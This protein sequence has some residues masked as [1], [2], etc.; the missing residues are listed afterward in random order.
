MAYWYDKL[1]ACTLSWLPVSVDRYITRRKQQMHFNLAISSVSEEASA[2]AAA[3]DFKMFP[4]LLRTS[5]KSMVST[6]DSRSLQSA[7]GG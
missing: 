6:A 5:Q 1:A 3:A 2:E 7:S 4:T